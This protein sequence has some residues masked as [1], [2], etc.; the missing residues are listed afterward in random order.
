MLDVS[1][2]IEEFRLMWTEHWKYIWGHHE[3]GTVDCSGAFYYVFKLKHSLPMYNGSNRIA[4]VYVE[5]LIPY[6]Y[7]KANGLIEPGMAAFKHYTP[8]SAKY[9]LGTGYKVK[10]AYYNGD[11]NDYYH[12]G[13]VDDDTNYVL[14]AQGAKTGFVR[15]KITENWTFVAYL[16]NV[17]YHKKQETPTMK[18][19]QVVRTADT[20]AASKTVNVRNKPNGGLLFTVKFGDIVNVSAEQG[21][22]TQIS[23]AGRTGWMMSKFLHITDESTGS[24]TQDT[25][26]PT[27][28]EALAE[29]DK[30]YIELGTKLDKAF[31]AAG[32][33]G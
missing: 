16:K 14:N 5:E 31:V 25:M 6:D 1:V 19:A 27:L 10:G 11:L 18:T 21:D 28:R 12:I 32:G 3:K 24:A 15:S 33:R 7:A 30:A 20:A 2:L 13:L 4:R 9:N 8:S 29:I 17:N 23:Y 22:W 26:S